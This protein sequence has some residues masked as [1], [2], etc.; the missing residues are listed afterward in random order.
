MRGESRRGRGRGRLSPGPDRHRLPAAACDG[1][2]AHACGASDARRGHVREPSADSLLLVRRTLGLNDNPAL[3]CAPLSQD[4]MASLSTYS[5]PTATCEVR[6]ADPGTHTLSHCVSS[7]P[8]KCPECQ[9]G[10]WSETIGSSRTKGINRPW[11]PLQLLL[12]HL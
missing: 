9:T 6:R 3:T 11:T 7:P 2:A 1:H 8:A 4:A 5:G 10:R 12:Q